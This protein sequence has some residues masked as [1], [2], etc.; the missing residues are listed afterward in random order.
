MKDPLIGMQL[1]NFKIEYLLGQGGMASVYFGQ[2]VR[3]HRPVAIKVLDRRFKNHPAY[4]ARF[5]NEARMMAQWRHE[6]IIQIYYTDEAQ[7]FPYYVMEYVDG[8]DLAAVMELYQNEGK[9]MPIADTLR[10]GKAAASALDYAHRQGVVHRDVKPSNILLSK[11]GRVLLGDFGMALEVRDGSQGN[12]FGTPHYI[13]PE[14]AKRS[15]DAV[16]QSDIYSLGVIL[17]EILTGTVPFNASSPAEIALQHISQKPPTPRSINPSISPA[18]ETVLLKALEKDRKERYQTGAKFMAALEEAFASGNAPKKTTLPPLPV[19]APTIQRSEFSIE[20][21]SKR[22]APQKPQANIPVAQNKPAPT[23]KRN[24]G[25]ILLLLLLM[26]IGGFFFLQNRLNPAAV[27]VSTLESTLAAAP[28]S[29]PQPDPATETSLPSPT[30]TQAPTETAIPFQVTETLLPTETPALLGLLPTLNVTVEATVKYPDGVH[31]V[32]LY[33][34]TNLF[35]VNLSYNNRSLSGFVFQRLD[36]E[37]LPIE[38]IFQGYRWEAPQAKFLPHDTCVSIT[39]AS[40]QTLPTECAMGL[41][42]TIQIPV[43]D[44]ENLLFWT[45]KQGSR[46]FRVLWLDEEVARCDITAGR[47]EVFIP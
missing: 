21:I 41:L 3:L 6:N 37:G 35:M 34:S 32:L 13:S 4:A 45:P 27:S 10:I 36:S 2:D 22:P 15:A 28:L 43:D 16:P 44:T 38:D 40:Q 42:K 26:G 8:Q 30:S 1:A 33:N 46:Q 23:K 5:V 29:S 31:F 17:Y 12:I 9:L 11:D 25:W 14:Q 18:V 19:G 24:R 47:C 20:Q 39:I 7:G